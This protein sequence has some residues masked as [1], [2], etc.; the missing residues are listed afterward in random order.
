MD[1][2]W[3][4][5]FPIHYKLNTSFSLAIKLLLIPW[6][7]SFVVE[8]LPILLW[9]P[10]ANLP[11]ET[12]WTECGIPFNNEAEFLF[13]LGMFE[14]FMPFAI[15]FV[16]NFT[17][18]VLL[19]RRARKFKVEQQH[20]ESKIAQYKSSIKSAKSLALLITAFLVAWLPYEITNIYD[21]LCG[22]CIPGYWFWWTYYGIYL[23]S[24]INP[25]LYPLMQSQI[26]EGL[27]DLFC[28]CWCGRNRI[29]VL[30]KTSHSTHMEFL[31]GDRAH[32]SQDSDPKSNVKPY[33]PRTT[34]PVISLVGN[35]N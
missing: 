28:K 8:G 9:R 35:S 32:Y 6:I 13:F 27:K 4:I 26:R 1:R 20:D 23:N 17:I 11:A 22:N 25:I 31:R 12:R 7:L 18:I 10:L 30:A 14:F 3:C 24:A 2:T 21:P 5:A 15:I 34:E 29:T 19:F 16:C 33:T